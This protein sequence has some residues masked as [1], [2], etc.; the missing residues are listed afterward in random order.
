MTT[1]RI[2]TWNINGL[3]PNQSELEVLIANNKLDVVLISEAHCTEKSNI[4]IKGCNTYLTYHP[5]G[6]GH[7]GTAIVIRTSIKH[8]VLPEFIT[9][10]IQATSVTVESN[11]GPLNLSAVYCPPRHTIDSAKFTEFFHTLGNKFITGG[12][13]NAK[14]TY[15]GSRLTTTRGRQL[16]KCIDENNYCSIS[17]SEPTYW[18]TD[19][20]KKPDLLDFFVIGGLSRH[21]FKAESCLDSNS[22]HTPVIL[23][24]STTLICYEEPETLFN[25]FTDWEGF[26]E[27]IEDTLQLHVSL[28]TKEEIENATIY[29]TRLIQN[30]C[31]MNTPTKKKRNTTVNIPLEIK[32]KVLEKR[33]LRRDW[34]RTRHKSDKAALNKA[35]KELKEMLDNNNNATLQG[36]LQNLTATAS[37]E[38]SLWKFTKT[39]NRPQQFKSAI[40]KNEGGWAK[41]GREKAQTFAKHLAKVF[42]PNDGVNIE[43]DREVDDHLQQDLQLSLPPRSITVRELTWAIKAM[44][45][46]KAPGFDLITKEVLAQLP[47]KALVFL[48]TLFNGILRVQHFPNMWKISVITMI[49]KPGKNMV[50]VSSYRPISLLPVLSKLFERILL[51]RILPLLDE[52]EAIPKHQFGFRKQHSTIE[53]VHRVCDKIRH[54]LETKEY[55]SA[56]FLDI[57]QAFDKVWHK[58]LLSKIKTLLPHTYYTLMNSYLSNRMFQVRESGDASDIYDI[59]AGVPQGSVLGPILYTLYTADLPQSHKVMNA[60]FADDTALL[61]S[62]K[63]PQTASK[64]L[65]EGLNKVDDW[66]QKWRIKASASK[67]THVTFTL[68]K[69]DCPPVI[70]GNNTL[71]HGDSVK[72]LGIH[73]D[74]RLTWKKHIKMKRDETNM[75]FRT[76]YWLL[77]RN[78][79][80]SVDNKLLI[81]KMILKPVW[82]YGIQLWGSACNSNITII[83][84]VQNGILRTITNAP[85]FLTNSEIHKAS[86]I[87]TI[88]EEIQQSATNYKMRLENHPN[89]LAAELSKIKYRKRLKRQD[90]QSLNAR[91]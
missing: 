6:T 43:F 34:H 81:Y 8:H 73:L 29:I 26:R 13:W 67:S 5:D 10:Q 69:G 42:Q 78:S 54:S 72:Y 55:C 59:S 86:E 82:M 16:K 36:K 52:N 18:P 84:R 32:E 19:P 33:K 63:D 44:Q 3:T 2:A 31:W 70:L 91:W 80:L 75:R 90:I 65:Q 35:I 11:G 51:N 89:D 20:K 24:V 85:W 62:S 56:V 37:S 12:D 23:T 88:K 49:H 79:K 77:A 1:L 22:D 14:H 83:Q 38:Y 64:I 60:T 25:K 45:N 58:G 48:V 4:K 57:Q 40:R 87:K 41:T 61:A 27:Y 50:D 71:P 39:F 66:L 68:K 53:Q 21:Y 9:N 15:W 30:A 46:H 74:R 76:M 17:S 47:R 7:A 28:K